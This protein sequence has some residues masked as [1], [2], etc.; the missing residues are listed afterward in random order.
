MQKNWPDRVTL[1]EV[2]PRDGFQFEPHIIPT[3]LKAAV[4]AGLIEAGLTHI[5]V[6]SFVHPKRVPQMADA[7]DLIQRLPQLD[8]V[9]YNGL[10]LNS[11]GLERAL[12]AQLPSVEISIS[13]SDTH[14][15]RNSNM[16]F[17]EALNQGMR[18]IR[19]AKAAG[20]YVRAG[21]Q[22]A[23]GCVYEGPVAPERVTDILR[24]FRDQGAD[25]V[26]VSDTTG[27]GSP[28]SLRR[29][30]DYL[31]PAVEPL[32][33]VLHLHDTRGTGLVNMMAGLERGIDRFDT[34]LGGMGGCP[35]I[36]GAAGNIAT[37]DAVNLLDMLGI[38][39]GV[40]WRRVAVWARKLETVIGRQLPGKMLRVIPRSTGNT[41]PSDNVA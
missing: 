34:A 24:R 25:A 16:A 33:V 1:M 4:V 7:E 41:P 8:H 11:R 21:A 2:G 9:H 39:T 17:E 15:R 13:A 5:Q 27:M 19:R 28:V 20:L 37:E 18:M 40:D 36:E 6:A 26:V 10:V 29:L 23:L 31:L 14:S 38:A 30:L 3:D 32:P 22:C 12:A 35:F